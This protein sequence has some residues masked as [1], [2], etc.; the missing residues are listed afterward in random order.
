MVSGRQA[1]VHH[2]DV[3][4]GVGD[5]WAKLAPLARGGEH[6]ARDLEEAMRL[7][8]HPGA[9]LALVEHPPQ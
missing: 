5:V 2:L 6:G 1:H 8:Q 4:A 7:V 9:D 3:G